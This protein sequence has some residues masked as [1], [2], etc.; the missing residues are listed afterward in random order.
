MSQAALTEVLGHRRHSRS[1]PR[2]DGTARRNRHGSQPKTRPAA[3]AAVRH[4]FRVTR[5]DRNSTCP[6]GHVGKLFRGWDS[7]HFAARL[8]PPSRLAAARSYTLRVSRFV[9][10]SIAILDRAF[11]QNTASRV[12]GRSVHPQTS[13]LCI[14]FGH[15][16]LKGS[17]GGAPSHLLLIDIVLVCL[18]HVSHSFRLQLN[19]PTFSRL[20][21][22]RT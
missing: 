10:V 9:R 21:R 17:D 16:F 12:A 4:L 20:H 5:A 2:R 14:A 7:L 18:L 8:R 15:S 19:E 11:A 6:S 3:P 1:R 22:N 13:S